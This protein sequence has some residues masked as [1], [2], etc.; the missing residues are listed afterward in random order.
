MHI[1]LKIFIIILFTC[2]SCTS[3]LYYISPLSSQ[4]LYQS[5]KLMFIQNIDSGEIKRD[6]FGL[7][8]GID[9][10]RFKTSLYVHFDRYP[11]FKIKSDSL[12]CHY[13]LNAK[14]ISQKYPKTIF[15]K[16]CELLVKYDLYDNEGNLIWNKNITAVYQLSGGEQFFEGPVIAHDD[17]R[18]EL[19]KRNIESLISELSKLI[20][21]GTL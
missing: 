9:P 12:N 11:I 1:N 19:I 16:T 7:Q 21:Q 10:E 5:N 17:I 15:N 18:E 13:I 14:L 6:V 8:G 4:T 20:E 2:F 3:Q